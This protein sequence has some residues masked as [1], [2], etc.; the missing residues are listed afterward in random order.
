MTAASTPS[1]GKQRDDDHASQLGLLDLPGDIL[2][3][4]AAYLPLPDVIQFLSLHSA[5][6]ELTHSHLTPLRPVI[7]DALRRGPPYPTAL[8]V[9]PSISHLLAADD[10]ALFLDVLVRAPA[11]WILERF[12]LGRWRDHIWHE[13]FDR[14]FLPSWKRYKLPEDSWRAAFLRVLGWIDHRAVGCTH[15]ENWTRFLTFRRNGS[16]AIDRI[17]SRT[18]NPLEIYDELK[19]QSNL[20]DYPTQ[21]RVVVHLQDVRILVIG[22]VSDRASYNT[23]SNAHLLLH[24]PLLRLR[25]DAEPKPYRSLDLQ[26]EAPQKTV[27]AAAP[28]PVTIPVQSS[29]APLARTTSAGST[30]SMGGSLGVTPENYSILSTLSSWIPRRRSST[31][32]DPETDRLLTLDGT[33]LTTVRSREEDRRRWSF[34]RSGRANSVSSPTASSSA[35]PVQPQA[36][37]ATRP[38]AVSPTSPTTPLPTLPEDHP[39]AGGSAGKPTAPEPTLQDQLSASPSRL[40][41]PVL[42]YPTPAYSHE[43]YPNHTP[44]YQTHM[45]VPSTDR[46]IPGQEPAFDS[47]PVVRD[48]RN[49]HEER[50]EDVNGVLWSNEST[51]PDGERMTEWVAQSSTRRR[52]VG[53][54]M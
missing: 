14:R 1:K 19:H 18:F 35:L 26:P 36:A 12:E 33:R 42:T 25:G 11:K 41:Y 51:W 23:N 16:A 54:V 29:L 37:T 21:M 3:Q 22:V 28:A 47:V 44:S 32:V 9:L 50:E 46:P 20:G 49:D 5:I 40:P 31:D 34:S 24:P 45:L 2:S 53:P 13:A 15:H 7:R 52:W 27:K 39:E 4:I 8:E 17:Y 43:L 30:S 10:G 38:S 6:H 48:L